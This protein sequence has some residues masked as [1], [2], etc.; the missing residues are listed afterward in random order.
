M[1]ALHSLYVARDKDGRVFLYTRKPRKYKRSGRW[2]LRNEDHIGRLAIL[3]K[4]KDKFI[5]VK[6]NDKEPWRIIDLRLF[7]VGGNYERQS[8]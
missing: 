8:C 1:P 5:D 2:Y 4:C 7:Q 6:W 3:G